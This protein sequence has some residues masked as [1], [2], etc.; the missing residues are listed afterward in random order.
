MLFLSHPIEEIIR[1]NSVSDLS[2]W[3]SHLKLPIGVKQSEIPFNQIFS[4]KKPVKNWATIDIMDEIIYGKS[5][6]PK[7]HFSPVPKGVNPNNFVEDLLSQRS[8]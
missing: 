5:K 7:N 8:S 1:A 3:S 2:D 6:I 4:K